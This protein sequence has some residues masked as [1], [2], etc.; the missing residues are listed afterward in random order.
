MLCVIVDK[1]TEELRWHS[2]TPIQKL[3]MEAVKHSSHCPF[4]TRI[5]FYRLNKDSEYPNPFRI[6]AYRQMDTAN[7][8]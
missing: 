8:V 4:W 5:I 1:T 6:A 7:K 2:T 3:I